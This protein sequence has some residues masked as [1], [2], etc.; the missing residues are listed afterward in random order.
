MDPTTLCGP[1]HSQMIVDTYTK[2]IATIKEQGGKII[3]G[4]K[5]ID[6]PGHYLEPT[7]VEIAHDAPI[8]QEELFGTLSAI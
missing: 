2:G 4:G 8:V 7:L 6:Q 3:Y 1:A 5:L